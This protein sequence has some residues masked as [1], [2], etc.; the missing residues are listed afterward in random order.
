MKMLSVVAEETEIY[1]AF[2]PYVD[3][4][5]VPSLPQSP[6]KKSNLKTYNEVF[7]LLRGSKI[8]DVKTILRE[9]E[10]P[11]SSTV[12]SQLWPLLTSQHGKDEGASN[13]AFYWD[14]VVQLFGSKDL[15]DRPLLLPQFA[16]PSHCYTYHLDRKGRLVVERII[17]VLGYACPD[18][19]YSPLAFSLTALLLHF[20]TEDAC[21]AAMA[22]LMS[23]KTLLF[24]TQTKLQNEVTWRTCMLLAKKH[25]KSTYVVLQ[26]MCGG[27]I[28]DLEFFFKDWLWWIFHGIPFPHLVRVA[29]S[30]LMEGIKVLY[31]VA[32]ALA[33]LF[34]K[35]ASNK[36]TTWEADFESGHLNVAMTHFCNDL[37]V[38]PGKLLRAA[39][40][41]RNFSGA[42]V[43]KAQLRTDMLLKTR[44]AAATTSGPNQLTRSR[45]SENLPTA[46]S[47]GAVKMASHTLTIKELL[48]VWSWLPIRITMYQPV[49]LYTTEEHGCS[50]TTFFV[51]VEKHE[52][53]ILIIKTCA[54]EVF[55]AY[56]S[57]MWMERNMKDDK[58]L[59]QAY[60]G[61]GETFV[62][63]LSPERRKYGW[64][65]QNMIE[66]DDGNRTNDMGHAAELFMAADNHMITIGGGGGQAIW[67]DENIRFGKTE[68]C[69]T[70]NNPPLCPGGDFE[71]QVLEVYGFA[72]M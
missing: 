18:V 27:N 25:A 23:C 9:N 37:P 39:F 57:T 12:R 38:T 54:G 71:I 48:T 58:G 65:G 44:A 14:M 8:R 36:G 66:D 67:M 40:G 69:L 70:F 52:P 3:T 53:T 5:N 45:S 16:E 13:E 56:C 41:L 62:F 2:G 10:W 32:I 20:M 30:Y 4:E 24:V 28:A 34:S 59:R 60:F 46:Q 26:K 6:T 19:T 29:D 31:R 11:I 43:A 51:R 42:G 47:Q 68:K 49:L 63:S 64:V 61:T 72:G 55:G 17:S 7:S 21:Y 50:L 15:P 33:S 22:N 1:E 35:M